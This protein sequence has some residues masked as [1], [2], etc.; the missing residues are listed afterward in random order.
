MDTSPFV[1]HAAPILQGDSALSDEHRAALW[2]IFHNTKSSD[3]LA[4][5]LAP[6]PVSNDTKHQLFQA[7]QTIAAP[8]SPAKPEDV[9]ANM[10]N[11]DP[12]ALDIAESHPTVLKTLVAAMAQAETKAPTSDDEKRKKGQKPP[13]A[14]RID[15]MPHLP[16]IPEGSYRIKASDGS[17][18]DLP[19]DRIGDA[20]KIDPNLHVLNP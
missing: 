7:K 16:E 19:Q 10:A 14:P 17:I 18:H 5:K 3:E 1:D 12:A 13:L 9:I 6:I 8:A 11:M 2:D 20:Q 4:Q 15:G